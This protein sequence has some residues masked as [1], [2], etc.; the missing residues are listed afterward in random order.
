MAA[1]RGR[2]RAKEWMAGYGGQHGH[3]WSGGG[4]D[5]LAGREMRLGGGEQAVFHM[6]GA[7]TPQLAPQAELIKA[8]LG[9]G[10]ET[11]QR[12]TFYEPAD[13]RAS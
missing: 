7:K 4:N 13:Q 2:Q 8:I 11:V 6:A 9:T 10:R 1:T 5:N 3:E 12:D